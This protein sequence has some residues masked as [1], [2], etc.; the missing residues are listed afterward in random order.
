[1]DQLPTHRRRLPPPPIEEAPKSNG[2]II[3]TLRV[4]LVIVPI[5]A[6]LYVVLAVL[7]VAGKM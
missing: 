5:A 1:M 7:H 6:A 2:F 3:D 4:A